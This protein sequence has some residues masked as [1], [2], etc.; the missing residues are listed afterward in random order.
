MRLHQV[1]K[2]LAERKASGQPW[3][4]FLRVP[5]MSAGLYVLAAGEADR[6]EPHTEDEVYYV[7][8]GRGTIRV[9]GGDHL[10]SSG[11]FV[12]VEAG[13]EHRFH[14][15][16][17]ELVLLVFFAPAEYSRSPGGPPSAAERE[18]GGS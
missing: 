8:R 6:Q 17:E 5:A 12:F 11:S 9:D 18:A 13:A 3:L 4:E 10:V 15:I 7:L 14:S 16:G 1:E 2:L